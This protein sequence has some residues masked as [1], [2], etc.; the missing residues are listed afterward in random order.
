MMLYQPREPVLIAQ[1]LSAI[2][3]E[4]RSHPEFQR[5]VF[6]E[7]IDFIELTLEAYKEMR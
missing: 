1:A 7:F 5:I 4:T 3:I 2:L 6:F